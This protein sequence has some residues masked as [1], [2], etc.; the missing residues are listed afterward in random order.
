MSKCS[1]RCRVSKPITAC[2][3]T[4]WVST[5]HGMK[6]PQR[7]KAVSAARPLERGVITTLCQFLSPV[8][9]LLEWGLTF[10]GVHALPF[11]R[12][13]LCFIYHAPWR[14]GTLGRVTCGQK[15]AAATSVPL[16]PARPG[17]I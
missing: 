17:H 6:C 1:H 2:S 9:A 13:T 5:P 15:H 3:V 8:H 10:G 16:H 11:F 7:T 4:R 14:S 12:P